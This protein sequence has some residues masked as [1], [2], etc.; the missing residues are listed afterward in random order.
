MND[1]RLEK[2]QGNCATK[3]PEECRQGAFHEHVERS[4]AALREY[5]ARKGMAHGGIMQGSL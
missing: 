5:C 2:K 4:V 3:T 1:S